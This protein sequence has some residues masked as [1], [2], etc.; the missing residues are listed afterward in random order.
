MPPVNQNPTAPLDRD[1]RVQVDLACLKC[2][3]NLRTLAVDSLCPECALPV[4]RSIRGDLLKHADP[5]WV[6]KLTDGAELLFIAALAPLVVVPAAGLYFTLSDSWPPIGGVLLVIAM[7]AAIVTAFEAPVG[8][9]ATAGGDFELSGT[10]G[11]SDANVQV[12]TGGDFELTGGFRVISFA[13]PE[14]IPGDLDGDG[15]V[16]LTDLARLLANYGMTEGAT[17][18]DGDLDGD[19]DVDLSDLAGLLAH[20]G[21]G[22]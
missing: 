12:L 21:D 22:P 6:R 19:G 13:E 7:P 14:P 2:S 9:L 11:Q 4:A 15:D 10:V 5:R 3:Y 17:Y 8:F 1:D 18:E 20:Y 16:D